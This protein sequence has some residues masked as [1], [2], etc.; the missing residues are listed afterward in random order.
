MV[1]DQHHKDFVC[2]LFKNI[3]FLAC[4]QRRYNLIS[5]LGSRIILAGST[6]SQFIL[7]LQFEAQPNHIEIPKLSGN[8]TF[9]SRS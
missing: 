5:M 1:V 3:D 8:L 9:I 2:F 7:Y 6:E 4:D